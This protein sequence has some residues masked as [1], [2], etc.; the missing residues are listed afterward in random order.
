MSRNVVAEPHLAQGA[1]AVNDLP[2]AVRFYVDVIGFRRS[3]GRLLWGPGLSVLQGLGDDAAATC[4]SPRLQLGA[5]E[6]QAAWSAGHLSVRYRVRPRT[7]VNRTNRAPEMGGDPSSRQEGRT[8]KSL[9]RRHCS[10]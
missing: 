4:Q 9:N 2:A 7:Y 1:W 3:G 5:T 6:K 10:I 8:R